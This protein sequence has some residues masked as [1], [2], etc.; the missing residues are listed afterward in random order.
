[1]KLVRRVLGR[2]VRWRLVELSAQTMLPRFGRLINAIK[3]LPATKRHL[4]VLSYHVDTIVFVV[5]NDELDRFDR[6]LV[7]VMAH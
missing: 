7:S 3:H 4:T 2:C 6:G 5:A 1:M